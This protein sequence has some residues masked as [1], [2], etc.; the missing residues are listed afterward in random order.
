MNNYQRD[1]VKTALPGFKTSTFKG[2]SDRNLRVDHLAPGPHIEKARKGF[3][4]PTF[5]D[6]VRGLQRLPSG[7]D[8]RDMTQCLSWY[9]NIR[10]SFTP[11]LDLNVFHAQSLIR[12]LRQPLKPFGPQNLDRNALEEWRSKGVFEATV[13]EDKHQEHIEVAAT[14]IPQPRSQMHLNLENE[15]VSMTVT[16]PIRHVLTF[17]FLALHNVM[18]EALK[19]GIEKAE[20]RKAD[21]VGGE[22]SVKVEMDGSEGRAAAQE[23]DSER[24]RVLEDPSPE[25][26]KKPYVIPK[27]R[28][29]P[30]ESNPHPLPKKP[31]I[32]PDSRTPSGPRHLASTA[33]RSDTSSYYDISYLSRSWDAPAPSSSY[34]PPQAGQ[35][36]VYGR[37]DYAE[38]Q[39]EP[40]RY[41]RRQH[42]HFNARGESYRPAR[43]HDSWHGDRYYGNG[44]R[45]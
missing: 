22:T 25:K 17:P 27:K 26:P 28:R 7:L 33:P 15:D 45:H 41:G 2:K 36:S 42:S 13:I 31:D 4:L 30:E 39:P 37:R 5:E 16:L 44:Y 3:T 23:D 29:S 20:S 9:L 34:T 24:D 10:A 43:Q 32:A 21:R 11:M 38:R 1:I 8:A 12:A 19:M 40:S 18:A 35:D 6:L 14:V